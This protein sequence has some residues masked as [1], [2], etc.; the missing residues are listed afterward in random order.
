M[1]LLKDVYIKDY[2][3]L[4]KKFSTLFM[5]MIHISYKEYE[6]MPKDEVIS[7]TIRGNKFI[8]KEND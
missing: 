5:C 8:F 6:R 7:L 3:T 1:K 4:Q 2:E